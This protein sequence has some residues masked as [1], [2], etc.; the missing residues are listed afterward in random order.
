[1]EKAITD[2]ICDRISNIL[3]ELPRITAQIDKINNRI[4]HGGM[5]SKEMTEL[6]RERSSLIKRRRSMEEDARKLYKIRLE[7]S[8]DIEIIGGF[9]NQE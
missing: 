9:A 3:D 5:S 6:I 2:E 7:E 4:I 8:H 1:M